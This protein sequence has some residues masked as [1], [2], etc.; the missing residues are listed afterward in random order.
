MFKAKEIEKKSGY[1]GKY[2]FNKIEF[3]MCQIFT[4]PC[5]VLLSPRV[6]RG[7]PAFPVQMVS[8]GFQVPF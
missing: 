4:P 7:V 5:A 6:L 3:K 8:L 1:A 2:E